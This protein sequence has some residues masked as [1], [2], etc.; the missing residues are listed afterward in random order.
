MKEAITNWG[1]DPLLI[2]IAA[3]SSFLGL[4]LSIAI[5]FLSIKVNNKVNQ[6][7]KKHSD[8]DTYNNNRINYRDRL[9][10]YQFLIQKDNIF[11]PQ[12]AIQ[13]I[14]V[15]GS[16]ENYSSLLSWTD[17]INIFMIKW[18]LKDINKTN[19]YKIGKR[20]SYFIRRCER[21]EVHYYE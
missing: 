16:L 11:K 14:N 13:I 1:T 7:L 15:I 5:I 6:K 3:F 12:I 17:K 2:G 20:L 9:E 21:M 10:S 8:V 18:E 4:I 19:K